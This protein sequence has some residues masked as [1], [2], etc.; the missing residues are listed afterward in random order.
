[1]KKAITLFLLVFTFTMTSFAQTMVA[2]NNNFFSPQDITIEVGETVQWDNNSGGTHNVNGTTATYPGNAESFTSGGASSSAWSFSHTFNT[3]GTYDYRCDPHFGLGMFGTVTVQSP[4]PVADLV[5]TEIMYNNPG[6]DDFE[7]IE[8]YNNGANAED[9]E[10]YTISVAFDYTFPAMMI[11]PGQY[12]VVALSADNM[13]NNFGTTAL[14]W[15]S[16]NLVNSSETIELRNANGD[17]VDSVTYDDGAPWPEICDGEGPSIELCDVNADNSD[18]ANWSFSSTNTGVDYGFIG[19]TI[20]C[21]PGF[22]NNSCAAVP[23][24]FVDGTFRVVSEA[25]GTVTVGINMANVG[26]MDTTDVTMMV[27]G[28]STATDGDDYTIPNLDV[29]IG[30][31][32]PGSWTSGSVTV[33]IIDDAIEEGDET[34]E[35]TVA[36]ASNGV[37]VATS[38]FL[39]T[40]Q[41]ND[42]FVYPIYDVATVTSND[43]EGV[44][45]SLDVVCELQGVVYG[46]DMQGGASIQFTLIDA[47]GGIGVF[48]G[49]DFGYTVV[50]GN[51]VIVRGVIDQFNG[52]TQINPDTLILVSASNPLVTPLVVT[53]LDETT[54]SELI[55]INGVTL[56]DP[57]QWNTGSSFNADITD[58]TN[59]YQMRV[60]SDTDLSDESAPVGA[61]DLVGLGGQF[62]SSSPFDGGYQILPRYIPDVIQDNTGLIANDDVVSVDINSAINI[63]VLNNDNTPNGITSIAIDQ[64]ASNGS[65]QLEAD[66]SYTYTPVTDYCGPDAFT[67]II[68]DNTAAC[69]TATVT[70]DVICPNIYTEYP[71][72]QITTVDQNGVADSLGVAVEISGIVYGVDLQGNDNIQFTIIDKFNPDGGIG[73][74]SSNNFDYTVT[75]GDEV[76]VQGIIDQFNGLTQINPDTLWFLTSGNNLHDPSVETGLSETT[77]SKLVKFENMTF[78]DPMQW[79]GTGSGFNV[80]ITDGVNTIAMRID[81]DVDLYAMAIPPYALFNV[82]GIGGQFDSSDPFDSG[83]QLLP[84]YMEDIEETVSVIDQT[85]SEGVAF[86]PNPVSEILFVSM[87]DQMELLSVTNILGQRVKTI[88]NPESLEEINVSN[89]T[90]GLYV[91]TFVSG[92]RIWSTQFVKE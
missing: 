40:I 75:E 76:V 89:L 21:S 52:L 24:I 61:F 55:R 22:A 90:S 66:N 73:L 12:I 8:I 84:R 17:L 92:D 29:S 79:T 91:L 19:N 74:F 72:E 43:V 53:A 67:Y 5:I 60:D 25:D 49:N 1:M 69:D 14:E 82:T 18:P 10:G 11:N 77:E 31:D 58:G 85:I 15:T 34:I 51:E 37:V 54:E 39:I 13:L 59:T 86:Y 4:P 28:A 36:M 63:E 20:F 3:A 83:Y 38:T 68:C 80:D 45:D 7:F 71:I 70:I 41:D 46:I 44:A 32:G 33:T 56:V 30:G 88:E 42:G 26:M 48:S 16:G 2:V 6:N 27:T 65:V 87:T 64:V 57:G 47:T 62:D 35:L 50:E 81:N 23:Y 9:L 78:V